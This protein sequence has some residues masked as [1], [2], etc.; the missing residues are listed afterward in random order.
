MS[1]IVY[2]PYSPEVQLQRN[3]EDILIQRFQCDQTETYPWVSEKI[4]KQFGV[5]PQDCYSLQNPVNPETPY[6]RPDMIYNLL[7]HASKNAK[8]FDNF[9]IFDIGKTWIKGNISTT[10]S[11]FARDSVQEDSHLGIL[12]STK[13]IDSR[14]H[15][16]FLEG[17][18]LLGELFSH[19][20][21]YQNPSFELTS[22]THFHPKKQATIIINKTPV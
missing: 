8:F 14:A 7:L 1:D 17:K 3:L 12:L 4:L 9:R 2:T 16:P 19:L 10:T 13:N 6:L 11:P 15:D 18:S 21:I 22:F 5:H 20:G